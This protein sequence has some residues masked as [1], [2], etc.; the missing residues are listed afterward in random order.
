MRNVVVAC[1]LGLMTPVFVTA[2]I[3]QWSPGIASLTLPALRLA[4]LPCLVA[5]GIMQAEL[6]GFELHVPEQSA[7]A[8]SVA[9]QGAD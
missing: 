2:V 1:S 7:R 5:F 9:A 8:G 4:A 6:L 3:G